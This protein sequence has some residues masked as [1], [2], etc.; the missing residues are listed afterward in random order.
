M[1]NSTTMDLSLQAL[2]RRSFIV[3]TSALAGGGLALG[4]NML[5]P[6]TAE[7]Q[8]V[9]TGDEVGVWVVIQ[10]DDTCVIRIVRSEM[11]QGTRTGLAQLVAEEL[12]CDWRKVTTESPTAGQN[13]GR[14]EYGRQSRHSRF[15]RL[16]ATRWRGGA[17]HAHAGCGQR[18][19]CAGGRVVG[20]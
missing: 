12:E 18:M 5:S 2:S 15:A 6:S 1:N 8:T 3:G 11:G 20:G 17:H 16:C 19:V 10:P 13:R 4:I 7:A 9:S 14:Y